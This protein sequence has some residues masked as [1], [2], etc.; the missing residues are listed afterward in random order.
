MLLAVQYKTQLCRL[1]AQPVPVKWSWTLAIWLPDVSLLLPVPSVET[2]VPFM[3]LLSRREIGLED[4]VWK[5]ELLKFLS[6]AKQ[7]GTFNFR[8][9]VFPTDLGWA[10]G[11]EGG[12]FLFGCDA[13]FSHTYGPWQRTSSKEKDMAVQIAFHLTRKMSNFGELL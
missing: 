10:K 13:K 9:G 12:I 2:W 7:P 1:C 5:L 11:S 4:A 6:T 3:N 8:E